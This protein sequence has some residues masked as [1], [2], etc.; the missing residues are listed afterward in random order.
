MQLKE[1]EGM[2]KKHK[3][4]VEARSVEIAK[5][6][7]DKATAELAA[8]KATVDDLNKS[9]NSIQ[10]QM[11]TISEQRVPGFSEEYSKKKEKV[12]SLSSYLRAQLNMR[13]PMA[14]EDEKSNPWKYAQQEKEVC[15]EFARVR[16]SDANV[17]GDGS[18]GGYL[19]PDDVTDEIIDMTIADMPIMGLGPVVLRGLVGDLPL[20]KITGR[21][22][23]YML[24]ETEAPEVSKAAFGL[25]T[26]RPK[27]A[28]AFV[29]QS[30]RLLY[31][32]RGVSDMLI[33]QLIAEAQALL[34]EEMLIRGLGSEKQPLG[35]MNVTG[36]SANKAGS[37]GTGALGGTRFVTDDA[38]AMLQGLDIA[39]EYKPNGSYGFLM[40]PECKWG[41]KRERIAN[42]SGQA[43]R[44]SSPILAMNI[45]MNDTMLQDQLGTKIASTS[46]IS[47]TETGGARE[48]SS[49][50][51]AGNW[52]KFYIGMWRDNKISVS[53][54]A[55]DGSTGSA[56]LQDQFYVVSFH[57]FDSQCV[58]PAAF[59]KVTGAETNAANW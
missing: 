41:M 4:E 5:E 49:T 42:Y 57:E 13:D 18:Q 21:P 8:S 31:Q 14:P 37:D 10:E 35:I 23:S 15:E 33:K 32:S 52:K 20:P 1:L 56:F 38:A 11:R 58:R 2:L 9:I 53:D 47:N 55:G 17:A 12:F 44:D 6:S 27:K 7:G 22:T 26:L 29:K 39:N 25:V 54:Q 48:T 30:K 50:I 36:M 28:G 3:D 19:I 16:A 46:L 51:V 43:G 34:M 40:R 24:S 59:T 45:L